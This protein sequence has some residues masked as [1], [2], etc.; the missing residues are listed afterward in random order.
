MANLTKKTFKHT[1]ITNPML[2]PLSF[3]GDSH[4][5]V[6]RFRTAEH[7]CRRSASSPVRNNRYTVFSK[8]F[9]FTQRYRSGKVGEDDGRGLLRLLKQQ[10]YN[11]ILLKSSYIHL[12][13]TQVCRGLKPVSAL[14]GAETR[15][16]VIVLT[17]RIQ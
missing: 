13:S 2:I 9:S 14:K 16:Y 6:W 1:L 3:Q 8:A 10:D 12:L 17:E 5:F 11:T 7:V 4:G 15:W